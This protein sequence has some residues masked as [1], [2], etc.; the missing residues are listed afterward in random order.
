MYSTDISSLDKLI[1]GGFPDQRVSGIF[2]LPNLGKS[3]LGLQTVMKAVSEGK[4]GLI[5]SSPS[6]FDNDRI[7]SNIFLNRFD[8]SEKDIPKVIRLVNITQLGFMFNL[9]INFDNS[10]NKLSATIQKRERWFKEEKPFEWKIKNFEDYDIVL[11]D[12]FSELIK[13]AVISDVQNF[14][15]RSALETQLYGAMT[16]AMVD[17]DFTT[18]LIH[19]TSKNPMSFADVQTPFGG[20]VLMY[21]SKYLLFMNNPTAPLYRKYGK[22][23]RRIMRYRWTGR[24]QSEHIPILIKENYGFVE[25]DNWSEEDKDLLEDENDN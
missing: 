2:A 25:P 3:L 10:K 8:I 18:L 14:P 1:D 20:A 19:H 21:L 22:N 6:E 13:L 12:S 5:L 11:I 15:I 4:R 17:Y 23:I 7:L 24:M 9:N 16:E